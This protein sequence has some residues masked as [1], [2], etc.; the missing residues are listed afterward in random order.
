[1]YLGHQREQGTH[2][3]HRKLERGGRLDKYMHSFNKDDKGRLQWSEI[4]RSVRVQ[5]IS[6]FEEFQEDFQEKVGSK[7]RPEGRLVCEG[8]DGWEGEDR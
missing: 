1:M 5:H 7:S 8:R 3:V 4:Q 6:Q 2:P